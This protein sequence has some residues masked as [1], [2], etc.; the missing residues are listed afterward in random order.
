VLATGQWALIAPDP[1]QVDA[2][3]LAWYLNHPQTRARLTG[4]MVGTSLQFLTLATVRD[5]EVELPDLSTQQRIGH[6]AE[7][8]TWIAQLEKRLAAERQQLTDAVAMAV[9][10]RAKGQFGRDSSSG[11]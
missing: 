9:L 3:Y 8:T 11:S 6:V 2:A 10:D 4:A 1:V 7:L 5:F